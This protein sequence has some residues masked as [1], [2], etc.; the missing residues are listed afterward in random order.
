MRFH[1]FFIIFKIMEDSY[2]PLWFEWYYKSEIYI[3]IWYKVPFS[4]ILF[5]TKPDIICIPYF[6][7][8]ENFRKTAHLYQWKFSE[9]CTI[10]PHA[11][12]WKYGYPYQIYSI[13]SVGIMSLS[14]A[15]FHL[16]ERLEAISSK[17]LILS[18]LYIFSKLDECSKKEVPR[19]IICWI[20]CH[21]QFL[22]TPS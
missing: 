12:F 17:R 4:K 21:D 13:L 9:T 1:T 8:F 5:V 18:I 3:S 14:S 15:V 19:D 20:M 11:N 2:Q 10:V 6:W 7:G 22:F 16:Y